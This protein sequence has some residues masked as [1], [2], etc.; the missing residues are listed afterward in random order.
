MSYG[1]KEGRLLRVFTPEI[2][3]FASGEVERLR[4]H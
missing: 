3:I 2:M 1:K 4:G